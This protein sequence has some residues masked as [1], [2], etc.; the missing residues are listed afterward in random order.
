M[1]SSADAFE[2]SAEEA[3]TTTTTTG[4]SSS[5]A[6][7]VVASVFILSRRRGDGGVVAELCGGVYNY[8]RVG[9]TSPHASVGGGLREEE[10]PPRTPL[11]TYEVTWQATQERRARRP[12]CGF[13]SGF[14]GGGGAARAA[15]VG[16]VKCAASALT[17]LHARSPPDGD[18]GGDVRVVVAPSEWCLSGIVRAAEAESRKESG[19]SVSSS[20]ALGE[21]ITIATTSPSSISSSSTRER[22]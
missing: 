1:T 6:G 8:A 10:P 15:R 11:P 21:S 16:R 4:V 17:A 5:S 14:G 22:G 12:R 20:R 2:S 19:S 3:P 13:G 7:A 9:R 18:G